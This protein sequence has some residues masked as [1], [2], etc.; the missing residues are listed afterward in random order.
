M[1]SLTSC[2]FFRQGGLRVGE[3]D[4]A[5]RGA[6]NSSY[7]NSHIVSTGEE[8]RGVNRSVGKGSG[9]KWVGRKRGS[10]VRGV[11]VIEQHS[12]VQYRTSC[13]VHHAHRHVALRGLQ[14]DESPL[15]GCNSGGVREGEGSRFLFFLRLLLFH[16]FLLRNEGMWYVIDKFKLK[17]RLEL[18]YKY[19]F[20]ILLCWKSASDLH[21]SRSSYCL[22][23]RWSSQI[24]SSETETSI[25]LDQDCVDESIVEWCPMSLHS[26]RTSTLM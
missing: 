21:E 19:P 7:S 23:L 4:D 25:L 8:I 11:I 26:V 9:D 2:N 6:T 1:C 20:E 15:R 16:W 3:H 5:Q 10:G 18:C 17:F 13:Q 12:A 22:I 14:R 24:N